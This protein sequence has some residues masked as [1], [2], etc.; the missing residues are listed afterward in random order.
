MLKYSHRENPHL[1]IETNLSCNIKCRSCYNINNSYIKDFSLICE[2][3]DAGIVKRNP[4]SITLIGGEPTLHPDLVEIIRYIKKQGITCQMLTNG[5]LLLEDEKDLLLHS[6]VEAGLDKILLHVDEG[7]AEI[8][9]DVDRVISVLFTKFEKTK[10]LYALSTTVFHDT[11]Q[12]AALKLR[13][14][15]PY[16]YF[17]GILALLVRHCEETIKPSFDESVESTMLKEYEGISEELG[18]QPVAYF[19]TSLDDD[20]ISWLFYFFYINS[21][22]GAVFSRS[23]SLIFIFFK[24]FRLLTGRVAFALNFRGAVFYIVFL[25]SALLEIIINP[26]RIISLARLLAHSRFLSALR[27]HTLVFQN[28][29]Q[30]HPGKKQFQLCYHCPDA[31]IRNGKLTPLCLADLISP[32]PG[33]KEKE[34]PEAVRRTVFKHMGEAL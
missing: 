21:K 28:P 10:I 15:A 13:K 6:L 32:L 27:I 18:I 17:D 20:E 25:V 34:V 24:A 8:H 3:I 7:Q 4:R 30:Y 31:T 16:K 23:R 11:Q 9:D 26:L 12:R 22:T 14:Y 19:P 29:P 5:V 33:M 1:T 2:E